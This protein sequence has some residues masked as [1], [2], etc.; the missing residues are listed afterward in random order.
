MSAEGITL[1]ADGIALHL[2]QFA[3]CWAC[4][5]VDIETSGYVDA[6]IETSGYVDGDIETSGYVDVD[7]ETLLAPANTCI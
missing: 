6:D 7:I 4:W 3:S 2:T 1:P 5:D